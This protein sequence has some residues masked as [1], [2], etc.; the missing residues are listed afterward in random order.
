[1][2]SFKNPSSDDVFS[3]NNENNWTITYGFDCASFITLPILLKPA[4]I[5][6]KVF[7]SDNVF[8]KLWKNNDFF[9]SKLYKSVSKSSPNLTKYSE[10]I[11]LQNCL[12][13]S[14]LLN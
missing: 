1:M 13:L 12:F 3:K 11:F 5:V 4:E 2:A 9:P 10:N 14:F 7:D 8:K 6:N